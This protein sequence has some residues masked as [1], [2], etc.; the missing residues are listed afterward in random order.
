[1]SIGKNSQIN[2]PY[3]QGDFNISVSGTKIIRDTL[4]NK[5]LDGSYLNNGGPPGS[6]V[7]S[8]T[9]VVSV[10]DSPKPEKITDNNGT[11]L[12]ETQFLVNKYGP[13]E[14]YGAPLSVNVTNLVESAQLQ[15]VSPNTLQPNGF[16]ISNYT[17]IEVMNSINS[18]NGQIITNNSE[19]LD[20]SLL[21]QSSLPYL[22]DNLGANLAQFDFDLT[23]KGSAT[24][25][26]TTKPGELIPPKTDY[27]SRLSGVYSLESAIPG[28]Y[29]IQ[30]RPLDVNSLVGQGGK[31]ISQASLNGKNTENVLPNTPSTLSSP[32]DKFVEYMGVNQQ[33]LLFDT[34]NYNV[35]RPDYTRAK[36]DTDT[37]APLSNYYVGSKNTEPGVIQSPMD[38]TPKDKF[39]R[40]VRAL[41]YGPSEVYK[42]Y[43][44]VEGRALWRYYN[45]GVNGKATIDGGT[46]EGGFT[47]FG[48]KSVS[49]G[50][51]SMEFI[52]TRSDL[53]PKKKGGLLDYTQKIIDSA[54]AYG[55]AKW[56]HAG[57]AIDQVSKI[58]NDG[59]KNISKGSNVVNFTPGEVVWNCV[60]YCRAWTKDNTYSKYKNLVKTQG[61]QWKNSN[62]VLDSPFNLNIA[63]TN[64]NMGKST[65]IPDG[66]K[67]KKYMFSIENLAW[68]GTGKQ[69]NLPVSEKGPNGGRIMWFPPYDIQ[70]GDT[71]STNWSRTDFLGRPE[72]IYTYN[73]T[74]RIG[75]LSFKIVVDHPSILNAI[76]NEQLKN[77]PDAEADAAL[78]AFFAGCKKYDIYTLAENYPNFSLDELMNIQVSLFGG[79][80]EVTQEYNS[81]PDQVMSENA[82]SES[83]IIDP[84]GMTPDQANDIE[85]QQDKD[86]ENGQINVENNTQGVIG[87]G[88]RI[89]FTDKRATITKIVRKM[90]GEENYF[91]FIKEEYPFLYKS[92]RDNLKFFH[93]AFH[94]ITP[95][96]LNSRLTFLLQIL[97]PGETIP[98]TTEQGTTMVDA[99]NTAFGPPP[100][101]VLRIG[102]FYH[103]KVVF[104]SVSYSY[105]ENILDLNPEGI[106]VQPM[107]VS[108]QTNFKF[109]GGQGLEGPVSQLQN[110]L[111]FSYFG[112]TELYDERAQKQTIPDIVTGNYDNIFSNM[113]KKPT[114]PTNLP[115]GDTSGGEQIDPLSLTPKEETTE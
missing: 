88:F 56:K 107:I 36:T 35:Y 54:P 43:D 50:N 103:S 83:D 57:N 9:Q 71:N 59:Y 24:S 4:L 52:L 15:Y 72:P 96:G 101:C 61:N 17:A 27:L 95:E 23:D 81:N 98:T 13:S 87:G 3:T 63:P 41:V 70:V 25:N 55:G 18:V 97:R 33:S 2:Y 102:D 40:Q 92:L 34:L 108:V 64:P 28:Y 32:S 84:L 31:N 112:N 5:N 104:D 45:F 39:D 115:D 82:G 38:A 86:G 29:F 110:A 26:I 21:I 8:H 16:I 6:A 51:Q 11:L 77:L 42:E 105:D 91:N 114:G 66:L 19:I 14:G 75:T 94:A 73:N 44:N 106:G 69:S 47:W 109:I 49:S 68:R 93:P 22:K 12:K 62:S 100:I 10:V 53:K 90:L 89:G 113:F 80:K 20:D 79:S 46:L 67:V 65:T 48:K 58:F 37:P 74:E 1:M 111:S 30:P 78:E 99:D 60:E 7:I 76:T 85:N